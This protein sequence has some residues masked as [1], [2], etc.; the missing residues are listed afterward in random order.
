MSDADWTEE[1]SSTGAEAARKPGWERELVQ[2]LAFAALKEQR[3]ARRWGIFF[4]LLLAGYLLA[5]LLLARF[6]LQEEIVHGKHTALVELDGIIAAGSEANADDINAAL[7]DAFEAKRSQAVILRINS[8]GGSPVQADQIYHEI[9]RLREQY[10]DKPLYAVVSDVCASGG[11]YVAAAADRIFVNKS[12][13][14]GSIGV[15]MDGFGFVEAIDRLGIERRLLTAGEHKG[16]LDPFLPAREDEVEF[17]KGLLQEIHQQFI[18]AVKEGRGERLKDDPRLFSGLMWTGSQGIEL[19]LAD[20]F[21]SAGYVA[22]EVV[23]A[24]DLL[25]YT[26]RPDFLKRL[27]ERIGVAMGRAL[28]SL[29]GTESLQLR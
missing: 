12:S 6:D 16:L 24:E 10:P 20:G 13:I 22:R 21:G 23:G 11:Y 18:A 14:I 15:R 19:G 26:R 27:S 9:R 28:V 2:D 3:R 29:L 7:R 5:I 8:P 17:I 25:D 1:K 4:K